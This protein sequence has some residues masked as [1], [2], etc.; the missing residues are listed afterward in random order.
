MRTGLLPLLAASAV[1]LIAC[2]GGRSLVPEEGATARPPAAPDSFLV[3]FE[4]TEGTFT[5]AAHRAWS[6]AGVDRFYDLVRRGYYR[7]IVIYRVVEGYVAQFGI[8]DDPGVNR[9]WR[10]R[11]LPDEPVRVPNRRGR[12]SFARGG[13]ESRTVQLFIN[14][15]DNDPRLDTLT[16]GGIEG[17]P[18]IGEV[19]EGMD[20]V[21]RFEDGYGNEPARRQDSIARLGNDY[22]ERAFPELDRIL[23][24]RIVREWPPRER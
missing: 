9:A 11:G 18:P 5:V 17:Y 22:L 12:V 7:D 3:D 23:E 20:V 6:P 1:L 16:V 8:H 24:T 2:G 15:E 10:D 13:P 19:V 21:D 4:T 14:L